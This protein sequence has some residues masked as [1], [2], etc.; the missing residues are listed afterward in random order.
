MTEPVFTK[1]RGRITP[2]SSINGLYSG[3]LRGIGGNVPTDLLGLTMF[4]ALLLPGYVYD[5]RRELDVPERSR[6][7]FRETTSIVFASVMADGVALGV[8]LVLWWLVPG[9]SADFAAF[10]RDRGTFSAH[11]PARVC[12]WFFV[13][14]LMAS[15]IA[16]VAGGRGTSPLL[17]RASAWLEP[18]AFRGKQDF[19]QSAWWM[20]F[21]R[22]PAPHT[23][24]HVTCHLED[25]AVVS[26]ML[27]SFSRA[28]EGVDNRE[29]TLTGDIYYRAP[30]AR[31]GAVLANT[32]AA[33]ISSRR[34]SL[35]TVTYVVPPTSTGPA[36]P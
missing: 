6:S 33:V 10:A 11:H 21:H 34:L 5:R 8:L 9:L 2:Y 20:L 16:Y 28:P 17:R 24:I 31:T 30:K 3:S 27:A 13:L 4:V 26:G 14:L 7:S 25:G 1:A 22:T 36:A 15:V 32:S 18:T 29:L 35:M 23:R 19:E 12:L